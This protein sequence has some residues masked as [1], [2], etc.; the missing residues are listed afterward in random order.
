MA[1]YFIGSLGGYF[2][3]RSSISYIIQPSVSCRKVG[4]GREFGTQLITK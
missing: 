2:C 3:K 4:L 1:R